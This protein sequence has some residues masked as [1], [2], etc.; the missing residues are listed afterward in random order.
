MFF[1]PTFGDRDCALPVD[2]IFNDLSV[3]CSGSKKEYQ[4]ARMI[5]IL[6]VGF[7]I[8]GGVTGCQYA[9]QYQAQYSTVREKKNYGVSRSSS[10]FQHLNM[11]VL[12]TGQEVPERS[13][14]AVRRREPGKVPG[15]P[16]WDGREDR[17]ANRPAD[18][19]QQQ[20]HRRV[21]RSEETSEW[22]QDQYIF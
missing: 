20:T 21:R 17:E 7:Q 6:G 15:A 8:A 4:C 2:D 10:G 3:I 22:C 11:P 5:L 14:G 12:S 19:L 18:L 16:I 13:P 1:C 9:L